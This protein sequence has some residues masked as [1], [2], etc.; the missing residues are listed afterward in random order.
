MDSDLTIVYIT[1]N[2]LHPQFDAN[3][4]SRLEAAAKGYPIISVSKQP[5]F[6]GT[7]IVFPDPSVSKRNIYLQAMEGVQ[8]AGTEYVA[9]AEDD[10]LYSMQH[11]DL[12]PE[13]GHFGYNVACWHLLTWVD[14]PL[15]SY[16]GRKTHGN[17]ICQ[18]NLY[19]DAME[20]RF[21]KYPTEGMFPEEWWA[22]PGRYE[23][24]LKVKTRNTQDL[25]SSPP[26][27]CFVHEDALGW[28][29]IG[30]R[31]K[32]GPMRAIEIPYWGRA[33]EVIK[34]YAKSS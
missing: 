10:M 21:A 4:R 20:E 26:N 11:F 27:I 33:D 31:L 5:K 13:N 18:R 17:L 9:I 25:V 15:F 16:K 6:I 34:L 7:N 14:P 19:L 30:P 23:R 2:R 28:T 32:M 24:L 3:V 8:A 1:A 29:E 12:R 22:E